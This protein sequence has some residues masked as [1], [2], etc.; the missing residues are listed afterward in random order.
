MLLSATHVA[1]KHVK[2]LVPA[3]IH[4]LSVDDTSVALMVPNVMPELV[5]PEAVVL[6]H[7][8]PSAAE[9]PMLAIHAA[10]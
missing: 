3:I 1:Y 7:R 6:C 9:S 4:V 10:E 2:A 5:R 8:R